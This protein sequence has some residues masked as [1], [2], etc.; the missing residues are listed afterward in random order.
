[1]VCTSSSAN[2][3]EV[4]RE[5]LRMNW[6]DGYSM[7]E[8]VKTTWGL[9]EYGVVVSDDESKMNIIQSLGESWNGY[10]GLQKQARISTSCSVVREPRIWFAGSETCGWLHAK[11]KVP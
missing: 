3:R 8:H 9:L 2:I 7:L 4:K 6:D 11:V 10:V 5:Y 1:M